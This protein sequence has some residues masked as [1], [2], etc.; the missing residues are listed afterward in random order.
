MKPLY[1]LIPI[2]AIYLGLA[3]VA[4]HSVQ[5]WCDE[6]WFSDPAWNLMFRGHG[7]ARLHGSGFQRDFLGVRRTHGYDGGGLGVAR[8]R[9]VLEPA[10]NV[11]PAGAALGRRAGGVRVPDS[12]E[13]HIFRRGPGIS[14]D[15]S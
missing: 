3:F 10:R 12:S 4:S 7:G 1:I 11:G 15:L 9:P 6:G 5:P 8:R 14:R 2:V 13:R